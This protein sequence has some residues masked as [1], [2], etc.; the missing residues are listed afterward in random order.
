MVRG[1]EVTSTSQAGR[2][3][4]APRESPTTSSLVAAMSVEELRFFFQ[5]PANIGL[6]LLDG[7]VVSTIGWADNN[8]YFTQE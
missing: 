5:V 6:K 3:R 4:L 2:R 8:V 1:E 7:A